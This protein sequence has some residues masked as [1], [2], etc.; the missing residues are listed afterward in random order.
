[1]TPIELPSDDEEMLALIADQTGMSTADALSAALRE[2]HSP[3]QPVM[4]SY[5]TI[6]RL[7]QLADSAGM[8]NGDEG[9]LVELLLE[10]ILEGER[11]GIIDA[12]QRR[13]RFPANRLP[14][15]HNLLAEWRREDGKDY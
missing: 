11:P 3:R 12:L 15:L 13:L 8:R 4:V 2:Y 1:M 6:T 9:Q 5:G 10:K 14:H 7:I